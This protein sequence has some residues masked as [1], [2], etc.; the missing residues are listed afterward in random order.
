MK[1]WL[2][3]E[4][5]KKEWEKTRVFLKANNIKYEASGVGSMV[6]VEVYADDKEVN[7][8]NTFLDTF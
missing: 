8:I 6:H 3:T 1:R 2:N 5:S 4:L 7:A